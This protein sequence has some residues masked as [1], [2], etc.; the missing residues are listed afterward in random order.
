MTGQLLFGEGP[1]VNGARSL[2]IRFI[3]D[4]NKL[5]T[6]AGT[7]D[8]YGENA[9]KGVFRGRISSI[10]Y[11]TSS[12]ANA[13]FKEGLYIGAFEATSIF[14]IDPVTN[15]LTR[16]L[17]NGIGIG[18]VSQDNK[19][20]N[21]E[22]NIGVVY[23]SGF[24]SG[25]INFDELGYPFIRMI[26]Q[27][28]YRIGPGKI[29]EGKM[30]GSTFWDNLVEGSSPSTGYLHVFGAVHNMTIKNNGI[31]LLGVANQNTNG[32][33]SGNNSSSLRYMDFAQNKVVHIMGGNGTNA[34]SP[35]VLV[36]SDLRSL[37]LNNSYGASAAHF[38][39]Y[40]PDTDRLYFTDGLKLLRYITAPTSNHSKLIT[41]VDAR[42]ESGNLG[43]FTVRPDGKAIFYLRGGKVYCVNLGGAPAAC[44]NTTILGPTNGLPNL[45]HRP[46]QF[47]WKDNNTLFATDGEIIMIY[48]VPF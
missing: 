8:V 5:T 48:R 25:I 23:S 27:H 9:D 44:D 43:N 20:V 41:L 34:F 24:N 40:D 36:D 46:N 28:L 39:H 38:T 7:P 4:K 13:D 26:N 42:A 21:H 10:A 11:Q 16:V 37:N 45:P 2:R 30:L 29:G 35:D 31:F 19:V 6:L 47:T 3:N 22:T 12:K 33:T 15:M 18:G 1:V 14:H 17:G 32:T